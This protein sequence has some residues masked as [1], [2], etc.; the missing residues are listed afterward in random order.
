VPPP[1]TL[2]PALGLA[3]TQFIPV[4]APATPLVFPHRIPPKPAALTSAFTAAAVSQ[5]ASQTRPPLPAS[6]LAL[7]REPPHVATNTPPAMPAPTPIPAPPVSTPI[8]LTAPAPGPPSAAT[9]LPVAAVLAQASQGSRLNAGASGFDRNGRPLRGAAVAGSA[10]A[11]RGSKSRAEID[12]PPADGP[13]AELNGSHG[14][15]YN[16]QTYLG[17]THAMWRSM[18]VGF[19]IRTHDDLLM[20]YTMQS[21]ARDAALRFHIERDTDFRNQRDGKLLGALKEVQC[22]P[23]QRTTVTH[24]LCQLHKIYS[25]TPLA[26]CVNYWGAAQIMRQALTNGKRPREE[27]GCRSRGGTARA[28]SRG[29]GGRSSGGGGGGGGVR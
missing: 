23:L 11:P 29:D 22:R 17:I 5:S 6:I 27:S 9:A 28:A 21:A 14:R 8:P 7:L 20:Q 12:P 25:H 13:I 19:V 3:S 4:A 1:S 2:D 18:L 15:E 24:R 26:R 10:R 16:L